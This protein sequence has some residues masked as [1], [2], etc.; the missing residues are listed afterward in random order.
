MGQ[1]KKNIIIGLILFAV[2]SCALVCFQLQRRS[3]VSDIVDDEAAWDLRDASPQK[4]VIITEGGMVARY[5]S[6]DEDYYI[7]GIQ[8]TVWIPKSRAMVEIWYACDG[9]GFVFLNEEGT[10]PAYAAPDSLSS[11]V[12]ELSFEKGYCPDSYSVVGYRDGWFAI[13]M[14]GNVGY[15]RE[16]YVWWDAID[17]N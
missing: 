1:Y 9:R 15:V 5:L 10:K 2:C 6:E 3:R 13:D 8:D 7:G 16:E 12:G 14:D 17:T 4:K 11:V